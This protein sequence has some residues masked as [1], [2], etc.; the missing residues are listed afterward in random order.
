MTW[1][2]AANSRALLLILYLSFDN[3]TERKIFSYILPQEKTKE[4]IQMKFKELYKN[5]D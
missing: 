5:F 3:I 1:N 4:K 2:T